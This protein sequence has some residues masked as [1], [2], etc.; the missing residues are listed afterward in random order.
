MSSKYRDPDTIILHD[1]R[2]HFL[3]RLSR[4]RGGILNV[5]R[6]DLAEE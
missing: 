4:V 5:F 6:G 2:V 1:A 3:Q